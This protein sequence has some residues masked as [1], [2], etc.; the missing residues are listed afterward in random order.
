MSI[1]EE[2]DNEFHIHNPECPKCKKIMTGFFFKFYKDPNFNT[3]ESMGSF[4]WTDIWFQCKSCYRSHHLSPQ[5]IEI[6]NGYPLDKIQFPEGFD[7]K[8]MRL[9]RLT[10]K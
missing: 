1:T 10:T 3:T 4:F 9:T 8:N 5:E 6:M 7:S 2:K